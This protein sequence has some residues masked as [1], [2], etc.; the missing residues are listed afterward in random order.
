MTTI[1]LPIVSNIRECGTCTKCCEGFL[2]ADI[3]GHKMFPGKPCFFVEQGVGCKDYENR[4]E[5]PCKTFLCAWKQ[6]D[7]MLDEFKPEISGVIMQWK[8]WEGHGCWII[9]KAPNNPTAQYLSWATTYARS[10]G[11]NI[12]WYID[13]KSWWI[14]NEEFCKQ[15]L[16]SHT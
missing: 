3:R 4:P 1:N 7:T 6:I 11:E 15:M 8:V 13:D 12:L 16:R 2:S 5:D 14:G 9:S 10:R